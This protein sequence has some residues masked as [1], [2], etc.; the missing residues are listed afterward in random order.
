MCSLYFREIFLQQDEFSLS[1]AHYEF[2]ISL[3]KPNIKL[4]EP[5]GRDLP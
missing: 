2:Q 4:G 5:N 3:K 1:P